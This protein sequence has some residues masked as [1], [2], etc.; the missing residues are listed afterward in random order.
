[1]ANKKYRSTYEEN[2]KRIIGKKLKKRRN[3]LGL[4]QSQVGHAINVTFQQV[5][6]YEKGTNGLSAFM[7]KRMSHTL[8]IPRNKVGYLIFK[9]NYGFKSKTKGNESRIQDSKTS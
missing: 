7:V 3:Q 1:M 4:T 5:Q 8:K 9:Y 2:T 6:K